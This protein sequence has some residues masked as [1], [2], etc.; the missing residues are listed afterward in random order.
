MEALE[1]I[2]NNNKPRTAGVFYFAIAIK[3]KGLFGN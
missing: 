3:F 2:F 1:Q